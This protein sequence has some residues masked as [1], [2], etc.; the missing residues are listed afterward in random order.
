MQP[1]SDAEAKS[2]LLRSLSVDGEKREGSAIKLKKK[3]ESL[4]NRSSI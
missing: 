1:Q 2:N 3:V 4:Q